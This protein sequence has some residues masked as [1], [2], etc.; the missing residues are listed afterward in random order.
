VEHLSLPVGRR[1]TIAITS[2]SSEPR[3]PGG[4]GETPGRSRQFQV[5]RDETDVEASRRLRDVVLANISHE[6]KTPLTA[7]LASIELLRE[8]LAGIDA[9]EA[10]MLVTSMQRGTLRLTQ[11]IDNLLESVRL[12]SG[13]SSIRRRPLALDEV[14]EDAVELTAPLI[15]QRRQTLAIDLPYPLPPLTGDAARLTQVLVNLLANANKFSPEGSSIRIGGS[16]GDAEVTVWVEDEGPGLRAA[17]AAYMFER[18]VRAPASGADGEPEQGGMGL[19]LSI[20]RSI[21]DRHGGRV[22]VRAGERT[23]RETRMCVILP[24]ANPKEHDGA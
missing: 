15:A 11:L 3:E 16:V 14:V 2:A 17:T 1:R 6:F 19:G 13:Q 8:K 18:F 21:V 20:V 5:I 22:E 23:A 10:E 7:Q 9:A 4:D 24:R 12:E